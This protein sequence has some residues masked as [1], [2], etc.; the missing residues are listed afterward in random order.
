MFQVHTLLKG[1]QSECIVAGHQQQSHNVLLALSTQARLPSSSEIHLTTQI[2][3]AASVLDDRTPM[4][5]NTEISISRVY[6]YVEHHETSKRGSSMCHRCHSQRACKNRERRR[7][8]SITH[9]HTRLHMISRNVGGC[10]E[11]AQHERQADERDGPPSCDSSTGP[12]CAPSGLS[13]L[14]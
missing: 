13:L 14:C 12:C 3:H 11:R 10:A 6:E 4:M 5:V 1:Q 7:S 8:T 9:D 2:C